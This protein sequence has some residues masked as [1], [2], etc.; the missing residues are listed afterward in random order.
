MKSDKG[1][2]MEGFFIYYEEG[3]TEK[4]RAYLV[5][6]VG[7][8]GLLDSMAGT[9]FGQLMELYARPLKDLDEIFI[10]VNNER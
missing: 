2:W 1:N 7:D 3:N 10:K 8:F 6:T 4:M 9:S 5:A